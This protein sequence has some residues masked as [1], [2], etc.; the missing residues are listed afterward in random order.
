VGART[1]VC[2]AIEDLRF[3]LK[4]LYSDRDLAFEVA[5]IAGL[6]FRGDP[7]DLEEML[8]NL[9]DN[10]CKWARSRVRVTAARDGERLLLTVEDDGPGIPPPARDAALARGGRLDEAVAGSGLGL[11]IV[12]D[13]LELYRGGLRMEASPLGGLKVVLDLPAADA[14]SEIG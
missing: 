9:M 3:S 14:S 11:A 12:R 2:G 4:R 10:A 7:Q 8:G 5:G 6:V 13:L 1:S